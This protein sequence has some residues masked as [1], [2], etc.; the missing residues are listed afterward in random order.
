[1]IKNA[2]FRPV[3]DDFNPPPV[4]EGRGVN[5]PL[6]VAVRATLSIPSG[7]SS[8][9]VSDAD[10][11]YITGVVRDGLSISYTIQGNILSFSPISDKAIIE[12]EHSG[13]I[14]VFLNTGELVP[15]LVID[16]LT[17]KGIVPNVPY[18]DPTHYDFVLRA[19]WNN[20][21]ADLSASIQAFPQDEQ[22]TWNTESLPLLTS[23]DGLIDQPFYSYG[24]VS[25]GQQFEAIIDIINPDSTPLKVQEQPPNNIVSDNNIYGT[26]P[27]GIEVSNNPLTLSGF[28][29]AEAASGDYLFELFIDEDGAPE[30]I[31]IHINVP[32]NS[33]D[34]FTAINRLSWVSDT[35]LGNVKEGLP[36]HLSIIANHNLG[37]GV[38]Y[39]LAEG[40]RQLPSG[41]TLNRHG[42]ITGVVPHVSGDRIFEFSAKATSGRFVATRTF[43][44]TIE[45]TFSN[46]NY[47]YVS[48]LLAGDIRQKFIQYSSQ[49]DQQD[50][51]HPMDELF[52]SNQYISLLRG[53]SGNVLTGLTYDRPF[54]AILGPFEFRT[55]YFNDKPLYD[56]IIRR[57]STPM[58]ASGG[59]AIGNDVIPTPV[60]YPQN[61]DTFIVEGS[62]N[63]LRKNIVEQTTLN[64]NNQRLGPNGGELLDYWMDDYFPAAIVANVQHGRG[65][66]IHQRLD[67]GD[68]PIGTVVNFDRIAVS[69]NRSSYFYFFNADNRTDRIVFAD[70]E[71]PT[72]AAVNGISF[73]SKHPMRSNPIITWSSSDVVQTYLIRIY[74]G[75]RLLSEVLIDGT[76]YEYSDAQQIVDGMPGFVRFELYS[77]RGDQRS[78][79][80]TANVPIKLGWNYGWGK[81]YS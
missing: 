13:E 29:P 28:I 57:L 27:I 5:I 73:D 10:I 32:I 12:I 8:V 30:P 35:D 4:H 7:G 69:N 16:G 17:I 77:L 26:L 45:Q 60:S 70:P 79:P 49:I 81:L 62:F 55:A 24:S 21:P 37:G 56:V 68:L 22:I 43:Q 53:V 72:N 44:F 59:F 76:Y 54:S 71:Q 15:S 11:P 23:N 66:D 33:F 9:L 64:N 78:Q 34:T 20:L 65:N 25:R 38:S 47:S 3:W 42:E 58:D 18:P 75:N 52:R 31:I 2:Y 39:S 6:P 36:C 40:S 19:I 46:S 61:P 51:F 63:N 41:L 14:M 50:L 74:N 67:Y 80:I 1:M 48:L